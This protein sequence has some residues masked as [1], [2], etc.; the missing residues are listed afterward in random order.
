MIV[1]FAKLTLIVLSIIT[2]SAL[3][4]YLLSGYNHPE[5]SFIINMNKTLASSSVICILVSSILSTFKKVGI[6]FSQ[7]INFFIKHLGLTGFYL[8]SIH[9]LFTLLLLNDKN[10]PYLFDVDLQL[11]LGGQMTVFFGAISFGIFLLPAITSISS[12]KKGM[13]DEKWKM[14]QSLSYFGMGTVFVH[15]I[16]ISFERYNFS[17][18]N[19]F[20]FYYESLVLSLIISMLLLLRII[21]IFLQKSNKES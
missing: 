13:S 17:L 18:D 4:F 8:A 9:I 7:S 2:L 6:K 5:N 10:H 14:V 1:S 19:D 3:Y 20:K 12:V 15:L 21:I 11:N 16:F